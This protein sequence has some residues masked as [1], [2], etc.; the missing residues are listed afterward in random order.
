MVTLCDAS[1]G[2]WTRSG[3]VAPVA[4]VNDG[5]LHAPCQTCEGIVAT[6]TVCAKSSLDLV[7]GR[8]NLGD[9]IKVALGSQGTL[10]HNSFYR[11]GASHQPAALMLEI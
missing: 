5:C 2:T 8:P 7:L 9:K 4:S 3:A 10:T 1:S 11:A 6:H